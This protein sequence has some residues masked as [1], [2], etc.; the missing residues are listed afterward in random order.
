MLF[1]KQLGIDPSQLG[2]GAQGGGGKQGGGGG[3]GG[4]RPPSG[5]KAPRLK[6]KGAQGGEPRTTVTES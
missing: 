6:Q 4:G 1:L 2:G 3:G 5:N